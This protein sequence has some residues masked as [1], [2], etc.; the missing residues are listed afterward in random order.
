MSDVDNFWSI[1]ESKMGCNIPKHIKNLLAMRGYENAVSIRTITSDDIKEMQDFA[2]S[3]DMKERLP[4]D[5]NLEDYYGCFSNTPAKFQ[6]L[7]GYAKLIEEIVDY[8]KIMTAS[9]GPDFFIIKSKKQANIEGNLLVAQGNFQDNL[10]VC[11]R[12]LSHNVYFF[13]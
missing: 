12:Q 4:K 6:I 7:P 5:A 8:I 10:R 9:K 1:I 13:V 3:A 2:R 11:K